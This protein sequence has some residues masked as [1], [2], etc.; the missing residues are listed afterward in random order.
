MI[1]FAIALCALVSSS[2]TVLL[3][4]RHTKLRSKYLI[5]KDTLELMNSV[6]N[7]LKKINEDRISENIQQKTRAYQLKNHTKD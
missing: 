1:D 4:A 2:L 5:T 6:N 3:G 7:Q